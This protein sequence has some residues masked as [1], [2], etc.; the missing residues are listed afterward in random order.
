MSQITMFDIIREPIWIGKKIRLIEAFAGYGSTAMALQRLGADFEHYR[1]YEIDEF[2]IRSYNAI[3]NTDFQATDI[4][5]VKGNDLGI[6]DKDKYSY[7]LTYSYPC[8]DLS[9]A[10]LQKGMVEGSG[11]RSAL[12]WEIKRL[13]SETKELPDILLLENVANAIGQQN[14]GEFRKWMSFLEDLGYCNYQSLLNA[15]DYGI[16]QNR[17]RLFVLSILGEYNYKFPE[18]IELTKCLEDYFEDLSEEQALQYI[19]K[20]QKAR[21]LLVQLD[22]KGQLE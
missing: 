22:E 8:Q 19:V 11:T 17:L 1:V 13:L 21:D 6:V 18:P 4:T 7:I 3:H 16:A 15:S 5:T 20:S 10:G 12:L 9:V 2:A 14:I